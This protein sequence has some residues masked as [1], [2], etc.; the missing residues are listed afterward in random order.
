MNAS[1]MYGDPFGVAEEPR[2]L[3]SF[4]VKSSSRRSRRST[5][6]GCRSC[7]SSQRDGRG[8]GPSP[9]FERG[10]A[11]H[12]LP[13]DQVL[14]NQTVGSTSIGAASGPRL[15]TRIRIRMSSD[16]RP[17]RTRRR[18]RSSGRRRRRR[19]RAARTRARP[20]A[21]APVLVDELPRTG[22]PPADTCRGTRMYECVGVLS[23]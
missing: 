7:G 18:R 17:W 5:A 4:S 20:C 23:R 16:D 19:C 22:T 9:R 1:L 8:I 14:R 10:A 2:V 11:P 12:P 15:V 21:A 3:V 6:S 13:H